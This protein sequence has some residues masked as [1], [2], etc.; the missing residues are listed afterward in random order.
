[1]YFHLFR[2][3]VDYIEIFT[4]PGQTRLKHITSA[5]LLP[6]STELQYSLPRIQSWIQ[7]CEK[8]HE[9]CSEATEF[10]PLRLLDLKAGGDECIKLVSLPNVRYA[11]LS[12]C[13]GG[14]RSKHLTKRANIVANE[15]GVPLSE[16]PK[17]F[18][19]AVTVTKALQIRYL[20]VD[21]FCIIQDDE[22]DWETQASL[23]AAIYENAYITLAAGASADDDGGF[24]A[25]PSKAYVKPHKI[26]L[27]V[28]GIS[29]EIYMRHGISHPDCTWPIPDVL[30]LMRRAWTLQERLL[31]KR[32][33]CFGRQEI[34]WECQVDVSCSCTI[35]EGP[36]NPS[37]GLPKFERCQPLKY[38]CSRLNDVPLQDVASLWRQ[39]VQ[40]YSDRNLTKPSDK[41]YALAGL[42][43]KFQRVFGSPYLAGLWLSNLRKDLAW[44]AYGNDISL[45]RVRH[46]P[47]WTWAAVSDLRIE[48]PQLRL[49]PTF[50]VK[51]TS[52]DEATKGF[53]Q[54]A[55]TDSCHL[56]LS[57]VVRSVS[58][59]SHGKLGSLEEAYPLVRRCTVIEDSQLLVQRD[60]SI[61]R[62][63]NP[64]PGSESNEEPNDQRSNTYGT[65]LADYCFWNTEAEFLEALRHVYF[66]FLGTEE[67]SDRPL[68]AGMILKPHSSQWNGSHCSFQ[69]IGWLRYTYPVAVEMSEWMSQG[70]EST[71]KLF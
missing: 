64:T 61:F 1:M 5:P 30:P 58:I 3:Y 70:T 18:R 16:L 56:V 33:L 25:E 40:D 67:D 41:L 57:G 12:H 50:Q 34:F 69:R 35:T 19:D 60:G 43:K 11:C 53:D 63:V 68:I 29:H 42:A 55:H 32:Y 13:W 46:Y 66:L 52:F 39:L 24:F 49:H 15:A 6:P 14:T 22:S 71:F 37:E 8:L 59:R 65:F 21:S 48:W 26:Y 23:M 7:A 9:R 54:Y 17:T 47:S 45:G 20:W 44:S 10:T 31:A 27:D 38:Q 4:L 28:D 62:A 51:G 2:E 36:F